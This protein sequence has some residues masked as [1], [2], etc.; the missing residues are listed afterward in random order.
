MKRPCGARSSLVPEYLSTT[1]GDV[2]N[3]MDYGLQL[4]RRFRALKFWFTLRHLGAKAI[5][6]RLRDHIALA[7]AFAYWIADER[8]WEV[9]A[10]HPF[11][12]V[13]FR[14]H[15]TGVD[16]AVELE[17]LNAALLEAVNATGEM[18]ISHTKIDGAYVSCAWP[19]A[20][21]ARR[22][23]TSLR[24]WSILRREASKVPA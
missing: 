20:T 7:A 19:S 3:Y 18:F 15:P 14:F 6:E 8:D 17:R 21:S 23:T 13:C 10:P 4:G 24:A 1:D 9:L 5:R 12:V 22:V 16:N 2:L 11:S